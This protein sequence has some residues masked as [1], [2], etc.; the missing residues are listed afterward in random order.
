MGMK[1]SHE[2]QGIKKGSGVKKNSGVHERLRLNSSG[3]V[4][5]VFIILIIIFF[6]FATEGFLTTGNALNILRQMSVL[7]VTAFGATFIIVSG[8]IDLSVGSVAALC[9]VVSAMACKIFLFPGGTELSWVAGL[10]LGAFWG[11]ITGQIIVRL[12]I[13]PIITTLGIM[14][15]ARGIAYVLTGGVSLTGVP[16]SFQG[17]GRGY[18]IPG[19]LSIPVVIMFVVFAVFWVLINKTPI[20]MYVYAIGG[21]EEAARLA[22]IPVKKVKTLVY[23]IGGATAALAGVTLSSRLG[24]GQASGTQG[25]EMDVITAVVLGGASI[26]GGE[27]SLFGTI[28]GVLII[29]LLGNGMIL[30]NVDPFFQ[31]IVKGIALLLAVG[32]DTF[33]KQQVKKAK[34]SELVEARSES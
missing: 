10:L 29:S 14:T 32:F 22:G 2:V 5:W 19:I 21:N 31:L 34:S 7:A 18:V 11:L 33:R 27:G 26:T 30:M 24:S 13:P 9:G 23:I 8:G 15:V 20:G 1:T 6:S 3:L 4:L 28:A 12:K 25:L 17:L 16:E